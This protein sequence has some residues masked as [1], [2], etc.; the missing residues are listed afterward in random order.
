MCRPPYAGGPGRVG[1]AGLVGR[2]E[3]QGH[4]VYPGRSE[5][6][7]QALP[8][9]AALAHSEAGAGAEDYRV[10]QPLHWSGSARLETGGVQA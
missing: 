5:D 4:R 6:Q 1:N 2:L 8:A 10:G 7:L 9:D 3:R